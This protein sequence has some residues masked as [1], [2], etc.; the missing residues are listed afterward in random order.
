VFQARPADLRRV[1]A[2]WL[3][4]GRVRRTAGTDSARRLPTLRL[5]KLAYPP[6]NEGWSLH[7]DSELV[8]PL[9]PIQAE[10]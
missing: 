3:D 1:A 5:M 7:L 10:E 2:H 6:L 9:Q 4:T 8:K